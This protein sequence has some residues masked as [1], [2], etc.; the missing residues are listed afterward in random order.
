[1]NRYRSGTEKQIGALLESKSIPYDYEPYRIPYIWHQDRKYIP[2]F[3]IPELFI[4]EVKGR[5]TVPDRKKHLFIKDQSP[6]VDI[7]FIFCNSKSKLYKGSKTTYA[8]WCIK[9][10][11]KFCDVKQAEKVIVEWLN[12]SKTRKQQLLPPDRGEPT[13]R[14]G[15]KLLRKAPI[16]KR[17][18]SSPSR[19]NKTFSKV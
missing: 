12:E 17:P 5:F 13:K 15:P 8:D 11:F 16:L 10:G 6:E 2:D 14:G 3:V 1:M 18:P 4:L 19:R 9:N 7:R